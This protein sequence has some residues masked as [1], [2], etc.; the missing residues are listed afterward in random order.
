M[1]ALDLS[2]A[3]RYVCI[4]LLDLRCHSFLWLDEHGRVGVFT[5]TRLC[6]GGAYG[7]NRFERITTLVAAW[8]QRAQ[9]DFNALRPYPEEVESWRADRAQQQQLGRLPAGPNQLEPDELQVFLDDFNGCGGLDAVAPPEGVEPIS[10]DAEQMAAVGLQPAASGSRLVALAAIAAAGLKEVGFDVADDKTMIGTSIISLGAQPDV[11]AN[12]IICP[13]AKREILIAHSRDIERDV[14]AGAGL[15]RAHIE[16]WTGRLNNQAQFFPEL[17]PELHAGYTVAHAR[18]RSG[19]RRLLPHVPVA[20]ASSVGAAVRR[21]AALAQGV[22]LENAGVPLAAAARFPAPGSAGVATTVS[23]ASG[24][25]YKGDAG[26]GGYTFIPSQPRRAFVVSERWPL[27]IAAA[28]A[29]GALEPRERSGAP[30][31]SMP[32][33]ELF[34]AWASAC[35]AMDEVGECAGVDA[36]VAVGDCQPAA[37]ALNRASSPVKQIRLL[38]RAARASLQQWLGVQVPREL[39]THADILSH[40]SRR[41]EVMLWLRESGYRPIH[42]SVPQYCWLELRAAIAAA[43]DA[44]AFS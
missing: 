29:E 11:A 26:V 3:Y 6:F 27:D 22:L 37:A 42:V 24:D 31:L 12:S 17:G 30:Q 34:A 5:D 38:L 2:S 28:L 15:D 43:P 32:A 13:E 21:L 7:P 16:R 36:V 14:A 23:D 1:Y 25:V 8:I 18:E 9:A 35:A 44:D 20:P 41:K 19:R 39:N 10:W 33:A 40:P 4:Q